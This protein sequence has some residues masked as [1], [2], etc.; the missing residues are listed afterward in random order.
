VLSICPQAHIVSSKQTGSGL[1]NLPLI[2]GIVEKLRQG[3]DL[4]WPV[5]WETFRKQFTSGQTREL[6]DDY[7]PPYKNLGATFIMAYSRLQDKE[8][9]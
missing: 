6:F 2:N 9:G 4:D 8:N 1:I 3:K 7:V 5:M